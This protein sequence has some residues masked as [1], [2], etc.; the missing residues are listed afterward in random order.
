MKSF[1]AFC[2]RNVRGG[3]KEPKTKAGGSCPRHDRMKQ[4]EAEELLS[5]LPGGRTLFTYGKDWYAVSLLQMGLRHSGHQD[6]KRTPLGR[7]FEKPR[8][9]S[10]LGSLGKKSFTEEDLAM[11]WP[12]ESETYLLTA[13]LFDGWTQ[14]TRKGSNAWNI[15]LQ[16]NLNGGDAGFMEQ[17]FPDRDND[18]FEPYQYID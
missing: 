9:K 4:L 14:T 13:G 1:R 5:L 3:S 2:R 10:W 6:L 7:L 12:E 15:A 18:P 8:L 16:L 17:K 11:C